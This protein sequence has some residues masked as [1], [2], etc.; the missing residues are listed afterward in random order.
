MS[1]PGQT[2]QKAFVA[3]EGAVVL[4]AIALLVRASP[5]A[6]DVVFMAVAVAVLAAPSIVLLAVTRNWRIWLLQVLLAAP[7]V[8]IGFFVD[9]HCTDC[10]FVVLV[11]IQLAVFQFALF[12][13]GLIFPALRTRAGG[14]RVS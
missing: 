7:W 6:K 13:A 8:P 3:A 1:P 4:S 5:P 12:V 10:G 14:T 11:P 2:R 9:L